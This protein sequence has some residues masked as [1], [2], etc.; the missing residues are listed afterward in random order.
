[1]KATAHFFER[2]R[3]WSR[4]KDEILETYLAPYLAKITK[5]R[6]PVLIVDAFAG[7]GRFDDGEPGSPVII[8][9]AIKKALDANPSASV[10]A[11]FIERKYCEDLARNVAEY[12][13]CRVLPGTYEEHVRDLTDRIDPNT[14]LLLFV[15]PY[16][17]KSLDFAYFRELANLQLGSLELILNLNTF[18][19]LREGCRLLSIQGFDC[20]Q[21][22][23][24]YEDDPDNPI[25]RMHA[26]ANGTYWQGLLREYHE[27]RLDMRAA[28]RAF[29]E[30]YR[31]KLHELFR[32]VVDIPV[33]Y[34]RGRLPKYRLVFGT[35]NPDG[36]ILM[37]DKMSRVWRDFVSR[38]RG[39]QTAL[40]E[41]IDYPD[42]ETFEAYSLEEDILQLSDAPIDLKDL[43]V[44][45]LTKYGITYPVSE[46]K[47]RIKTA[48]R[49]GVLLLERWPPHTPTGRL[50][51]SMNYDEYRITVRRG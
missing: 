19:F 36:L 20:E 44:Q 4:L 25:E 37:A 15:D 12:R 51:R 17:I 39:G 45:L 32:H 46:L 11:L 24:V 29:A 28:E 10:S 1:M 30:E 23:D 26:I 2:K 35:Q 22:S 41:G 14:S 13:G 40:F 27:G 48:E 8:A 16:G 21:D 33:Q 31:G 47:S 3:E 9:E 50:A 49:S 7:K 42:M 18:G 43:I 38:D 6:R 5:T 34:R